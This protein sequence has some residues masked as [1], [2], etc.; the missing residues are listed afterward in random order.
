M[1]YNAA[2]HVPLSQDYTTKQLVS[3]ETDTLPVMYPRVEDMLITGEIICAV[4]VARI[5]SCL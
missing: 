2:K 5:Q 4:G 1:K 3:S